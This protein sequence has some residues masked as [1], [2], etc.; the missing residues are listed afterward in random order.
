MRN[1]GAK[2]DPDDLVQIIVGNDQPQSY[3][4]RTDIQIL[5]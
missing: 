2:I 4:L 5:G 3:R 1:S